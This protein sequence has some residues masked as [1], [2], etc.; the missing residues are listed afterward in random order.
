M[1]FFS[2]E[3]G[4]RRNAFQ[5]PC[6]GYSIQ[7]T[8][9]PDERYKPPNVEREEA[10]RRPTTGL[11]GWAGIRLSAEHVPHDPAGDVG[12]PVIPAGVAEGETLVV[13][14]ERCK[15]RGMEIVGVN[16]PLDRQNAM[17]V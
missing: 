14:A 16:G 7:G 12:Q 6:E 2:A 3:R 10:L 11:G 5:A 8:D 17:L 9:P 4:L 1:G 15:H 13:E